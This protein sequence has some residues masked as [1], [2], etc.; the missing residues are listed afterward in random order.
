M[1]GADQTFCHSPGPHYCRKLIPRHSTAPSFIPRHSTAP[2][3]ILRHS[4]AP[5][6]I[7]RHSTAPS[8]IPRHSTAPSFML[9]HSTAPSFIPR[10]ST[11][12]CLAHFCSVHC[13]PFYSYVFIPRHSTECSFHL[14]LQLCLFHRFQD[15]VL[16]LPSF[17]P[18]GTDTEIKS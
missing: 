2:S 9:R 18:G 7:P 17:S 14:I 13:T 16:L 10:H 12:V 15:P 5:L 8:F 6:F 3:F 4:T 11:A 1:R